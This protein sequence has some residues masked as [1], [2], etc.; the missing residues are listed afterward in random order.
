VEGSSSIRACGT[1]WFWKVIL[2]KQNLFS[3][4]FPGNIVPIADEY[5]NLQPQKSYPKISMAINW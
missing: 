3:I 4:G 5:F 1:G 2:C